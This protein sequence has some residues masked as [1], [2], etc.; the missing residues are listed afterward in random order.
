M[1]NS[2]ILIILGSSYRFVSGNAEHP[3]DII[4]NGTLHVLP[5]RRDKSFSNTVDNQHPEDSYVQIGKLKNL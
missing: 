3:S 2:E 1:K 4:A 5:S